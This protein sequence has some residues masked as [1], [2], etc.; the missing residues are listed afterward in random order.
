MGIE[1]YPWVCIIVF[2]A[3][4]T[5]GLSGF[6]SVLLALPLLA[7]FLDIKTVIPLAA[8]YGVSITILLLVQLR[9]H[10]EWRKIYPLLMGAALGIPV[11]VFLLKRLN[12]DV[13]LWVLGV[14]LVAY[15]LYGLFFKSWRGNMRERW[16]YL[17]GFFGGC[18][19]GAFGASGPAVIVYTSLQ[20][21]SKDT[22]KVTLQGFFV[23]SGLMVV[24]AH[25]MSGVTT[26]TILRFFVISLPTLIFGTYIGSYCYGMIGE[27]WYRKVMFILLAFLGVFMISKAL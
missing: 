11:G 14:F 5:Q 10:L 22:I 3:A 9:R 27:Q 26:V 20:A 1:T 23:F 15:S 17:F 18:L 19:G 21:W 16:G 13:I 24:S 12:R 4:F 7:I 25:A 2:F 6:G 8:L